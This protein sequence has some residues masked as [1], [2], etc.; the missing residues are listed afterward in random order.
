MVFWRVDTFD[1]NQRKRRSADR[2]PGYHHQHVTNH[3]W[4]FVVPGDQRKFRLP[5]VPVTGNPEQP[6]VPG[7]V[8]ICGLWGDLHRL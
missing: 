5:H 4:D 1:G 2:V 7:G 3:R 8:P 6:P